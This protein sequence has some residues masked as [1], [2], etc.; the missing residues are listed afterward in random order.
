[1]PTANKRTYTSSWNPKLRKHIALSDRDI[2]L[3]KL[4]ARYVYLPRDYIMAS[5]PAS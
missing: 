3:F 5:S 2:Q 1:M 4:L